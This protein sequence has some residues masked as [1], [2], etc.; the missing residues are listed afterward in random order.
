MGYVP[1]DKCN[2]CT[3][4]ILPL[5]QKKKRYVY[6]SIESSQNSQKSVKYRC[7][8]KHIISKIHIKNVLVSREE[9]K[10]QKEITNESNQKK[11]LVIE[12]FE[13]GI[14]NIQTVN[15][16]IRTLM[17]KSKFKTSYMVATNH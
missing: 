7:K 13:P 3:H 4:Y 15:F 6:Q 16:P 11:F 14:I 17:R 8:L 2:E 5:Q 10:I 12:V 1:K 9:T